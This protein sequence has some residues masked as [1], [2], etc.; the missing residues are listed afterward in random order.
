MDVEYIKALVFTYW[1][2]ARTLC[3]CLMPFLLLGGFYLFYT[4]RSI[5]THPGPVII[6]KDAVQCSVCNRLESPS[7]L[8]TCAKCRKPYCFRETP[9]SWNITTAVLAGVLIAAG[10]PLCLL[11]TAFSMGFGFFV[12]LIIYAVPA[13]YFYEWLKRFGS[14]NSRQCGR[15]GYCSTCHSLIHPRHI[16]SSSEDSS[17]D[18]N[19]DRSNYDDDKRSSRS[20]K[21]IIDD[22]WAHQWDWNHKNDDDD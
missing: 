6:P 11:I 3:C 7:Y 21:S 2:Y 9:E 8:R 13:Y 10:I 22:G 5:N 18:R 19:D 20:S 14:R 12:F 4:R 15:E 1:G 16:H 17:S